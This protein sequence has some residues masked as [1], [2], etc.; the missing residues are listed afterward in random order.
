MPEPTYPRG[1]RPGTKV[2]RGGSSCYNCRW[3][4]PD[5]ESPGGSSCANRYYQDWSGTNHIPEAAT[6]YCSDWWEP[7]ELA[8]EDEVPADIH[9]AFARSL[10]AASRRRL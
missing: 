3:V 4:R 5:G 2:P 9:E 10:N 7:Q 8:P 1:H 6:E